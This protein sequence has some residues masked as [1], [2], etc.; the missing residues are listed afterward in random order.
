MQFYYNSSLVGIPV[1]AKEASLGGTS[2]KKSER[3]SCTRSAAA[4]A[5]ISAKS[6][7]KIIHSQVINGFL[8]WS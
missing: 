3:K 5:V 1:S 4:I 8:P 6:L 2:D 7:S